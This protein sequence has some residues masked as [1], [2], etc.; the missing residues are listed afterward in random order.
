MVCIPDGTI[1]P[2]TKVTRGVFVTSMKTAHTRNESLGGTLL[3]GLLVCAAAG[4]G[5]VLPGC[6]GLPPRQQ[7]LFDHSK[8]AAAAGHWEEVRKLTDELLAAEPDCVPARLLRGRASFELR[9][10]EEALVHLDAA[11]GMDLG[12]DERFSVLWYQ[13]RCWIEIGC[14]ELPL[15]EVRSSTQSAESRRAA[16]DAFVRANALLSDAVDLRPE[17]YDACVWRAYA[18]LRLDNFRKALELLEECEEI[19]PQR[20]EHRFFSGLAIEGLYGLQDRSLARYFHIIEGG[21]RP[22]LSPVYA[23]LATICS[24]VH[25]TTAERIFKAVKQFAA[26]VPS[27]PP[28]IDEFLERFQL[29]LADEERRALF[30]ET[31]KLVEASIKT[32]QYQKAVTLLEQFVE[33]HGEYAPARN[34]LVTTREKWSEL[35]EARTEDLIRS[36]R[37]EDLAVALKNY[38][39]ARNLTTKV[40]RL[41]VLQQK[42][43]AVEVAITRQESSR[44][45]RDTYDLLKKEQ[46]RQVLNA[47]AGTSTQGLSQ[48][49]QDL[50]HYLT[51]AASYRLGY[52]SAAVKALGAMKQRSLEGVEAMYGL[53]LVRSGREEAGFDILA[54]IPAGSRDDEVNRTLGHHYAER[55]DSSRAIEHLSLL[56][57]PSRRD[58]EV[59]LEAR[60]QVG[61]ELYTQ[62]NY[63]RAISQ[64]EAALQI[65]E[66]RL[67][68]AAPD[69]YFHLGSAHYRLNDFE[70]ARKLYLD[71]TQSNLTG[72]DRVKYRDLYLH[73]GE[74]HLSE[75]H[76][77][78]AYR[79]FS[80]FVRLGGELPAGLTA[81]YGRLVATYADFMPLD[82][83]RYW[84]YVSTRL[85]YNYSL[86][87]HGETGGEYR[88]ERREGGDVSEETWSRQG[89]FLTRQVGDRV[90]RFPINLS[91]ADETAPSVEYVS[92][93]QQCR[94]EV[95]A[96]QQTVKLPGGRTYRDCLK[97]RIRRVTKTHGGVV[98]STRD[99]LYLAPDVG[100]VRKE[101]YRND[102]RVSEIVLSDYALRMTTASR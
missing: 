80:E 53:A 87:L 58:L 39:F 27:H 84:N 94:S 5:I 33:A 3:L 51:G 25:A 70:K 91:P 90:D 15:S 30:E 102:T 75:K 101:V 57:A 100:Q 43:N 17:S 82:K 10:C 1:Q 93:D 24:H 22:E 55:S 65:A 38:E 2:H 86:Y 19:A 67:H 4:C 13:G 48:H 97:V 60:R 8:E 52:W 66:G 54:N 32:G 92:N 44:K 29:E 26:E 9:E 21:P 79:D 6:G 7:E 81:V 95:V 49:D 76:A 89:I 99:I 45:I 42:I 74:I 73:R 83:V 31:R 36:S 96:I 64:L 59:L 23:H 41:V 14:S 37:Q 63:S 34:L 16:Q 88:V 47:L 35:I 50:Y 61:I 85:D 77:D 40:E 98:Q 72:S 68:V 71:L 18:V 11:A 28:A 78:L 46:Y 12:P 20:W 69:I 56:D 62:G